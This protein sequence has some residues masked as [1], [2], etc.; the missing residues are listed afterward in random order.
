MGLKFVNDI[1]QALNRQAP[2]TLDPIRKELR[3]H[4]SKWA[5]VARY[6]LSAGRSIATSKGVSLRRNSP[7]IE[8]KTRRD[9]DDVVLYA[10]A[11]LR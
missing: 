9:G 11:T 4:R 3:E 5:E 2:G 8:V 1:P 7:D 10:R 6:P